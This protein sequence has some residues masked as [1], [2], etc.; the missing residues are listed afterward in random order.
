MNLL[1]NIIYPIT[2]GTLLSYKTQ[3][4]YNGRH[5]G[6]ELYW[7]SFWNLSFQEVLRFDLY[8]LWLS[9][10]ERPPGPSPLS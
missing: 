8:Q 7:A 2:A 9:E 4:R 10:K 5:V 1:K 6:Y 3:L